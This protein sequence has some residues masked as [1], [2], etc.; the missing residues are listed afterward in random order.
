MVLIQFSWIEYL[1]ALPVSK[2]SCFSAGLIDAFA[3]F[4]NIKIVWPGGKD[5][6]SASYSSKGN[7]VLGHDFF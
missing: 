6:R 5:N 3:P 7:Y 1:S 2:Y 4:G